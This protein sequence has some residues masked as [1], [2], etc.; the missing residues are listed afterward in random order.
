MSVIQSIR[1]KG[2]W[3]IFGII[4]LALIA[5][6]LQDGVR[7]GGRS[8][9]NTTLGKVN[10]ENIERLAFEE[11]LTLQERMYGSQG[12]Q[13]EQLIGSLWNQEVERIVMQQ[14][15][16][17]LGLQVTSNELTDILFGENSPLKQEFTDAKTG[18]FRVNDA[19]QAIASIQKG[20]NAEQQK[21]IN[22][23]YIEP[24]VEQAL[25]NKYQGI[26]QQAAY[27]PKWLIE[28]QQADNNAIASISYAFAPY[29]SISDS[30]VKVSDDEIAAYVSKHSNQFKKEEET[31]S[32]SYVGFD[33]APSQT[34]S[35]TVLNQVKSYKNDFATTTD[36]KAYV[37]K[38]GSDIAFYDS[39]FS[40]TKLQQTYKDSLTKLPIG[41]IYGP[42]Q[43]GNSY[44]M[45]KMVGVKNWPDSVTVRHILIGTVNPQ[46]GTV[47]RADSS[48]QKLADSIATAIKGGADFNALCVKYSDDGGSKEKGGVYPF[49][50]QGQMVIPFNDYCFDHAVGTKGVVKSEFGYHY[51]EVLGQ[52]N[53]GPAYKIAYVSKPIIASNETI[54]GASTAAAQ[55]AASAKNRKAFDENAIKGNKQ[56]LVGNDIKSNDVQII[57]LGASRQM[58]RWIY[59]HSA[60]DVSDPFELGDKYIVAIISSVN[61]AGT[62]SVAEARPLCE[63]I[64]RSIK[65]AKVLIDTKII[66]NTLEAIAASAGTA[67]QHTDSLSFAAPF[68]PNMGNEPKVIGAA[69]NK[70]LQGK[71]SETFAGTSGVFAVRVDNNAA[72]P[73]SMDEAALKQSLI[74]SARMAAFRGVEALKKTA[75]ITDN[76]SK[77]Y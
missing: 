17:K 6:I 55:F 77:F 33:A 46:N 64:V 12:A 72:K 15:F 35:L 65:K 7:R 11:K 34:D 3:I 16:D 60:G 75:S 71:I 67:V 18:V 63:N 21:M 59:E 20:K 28:K 50:A 76:R 40:R 30:T 14:E 68:I 51:T 29:A 4:A 47:L 25:R 62:M 41:G 45:A 70:S 57:G 74:Q 5:F 42:Y 23:V 37:A 32:I 69:F 43:D 73:A 10:G 9:D 39:Y 44:I 13:R 36:A 22:T 52:K 8:T 54:S 66:G 53:I 2:A 19:K 49:F 27:I 38:I 26:L 58:V 24:T 61:K 56:L 31:R 1:D 48:A